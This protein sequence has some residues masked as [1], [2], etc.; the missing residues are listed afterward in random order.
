MLH[1]IKSPSLRNPCSTAAATAVVVIIIG[2]RNLQY[3]LGH[4]EINRLYF[5]FSFGR[6]I[7]PILCSFFF[8]PFASEEEEAERNV[9]M[10]QRRMKGSECSD[11]LYLSCVHHV[12]IGP[13][14]LMCHGAGGGRRGEADIWRE[15]R[16]KGEM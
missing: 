12:L 6:T 15:S 14:V 5:F 4:H 13:T 16:K 3:R 9:L 2:E 7:F 8:F 11:E 1:K 10:S